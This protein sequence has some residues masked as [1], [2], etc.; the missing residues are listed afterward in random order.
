MAIIYG[1]RLRFARMRRGRREASGRYVPG[2]LT[3]LWNVGA[4][5]HGACLPM[6][7]GLPGAADT[8]GKRETGFRHGPGSLVLVVIAVAV[9]AAGVVVNVFDDRAAI[10]AMMAAVVPRAIVP[11]SAMTP[12]RVLFVKRGAFV[13]PFLVVVTV[14]EIPT[15]P[16]T[17]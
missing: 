15:G 10:E 9:V 2:G 4:R 16:G 8:E 7:M 6:G 13:V 12:A 3:G 1:K 11:F 17:A 14:A 5:Y